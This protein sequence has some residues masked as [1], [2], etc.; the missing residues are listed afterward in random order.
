M[1]KLFKKSETKPKAGLTDREKAIAEVVS[2]VFEQKKKYDHFT[3]KYLAKNLGV[4]NATLSELLLGRQ[5]ID[6]ELLARF[7]VELDYDFSRIDEDIAEFESRTHL[8]SF[9]LRIV[10]RLLC[11]SRATRVRIANRLLQE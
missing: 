6:D 8:D 2:R 4:S 7:G 10:S 1:N 5:R 11:L 3:Q 9:D